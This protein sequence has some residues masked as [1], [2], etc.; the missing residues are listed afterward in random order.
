ANAGSHTKRSARKRTDAFRIVPFPSPPHL[1]GDGETGAARRDLLLVLWRHC[2]RQSVAD[3]F[4]GSGGRGFCAYWRG[5]AFSGSWS[6]IL[7]FSRRVARDCVEP[8]ACFERI[9]NCRVRCKSSRSLIEP[10]SKSFDIAVV[11][12]GAAGIAAA[13]SA[14]RSG[15]STLLLDQ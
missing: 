7:L 14:G 11:G 1:H 9:G 12:S 8:C 10:M 15:C 5:D 4:F 6:H 3:E 13:V 2:G